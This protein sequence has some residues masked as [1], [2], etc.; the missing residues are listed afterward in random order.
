MKIKSL[1]QK[2]GNRRYSIPGKIYFFWKD[3]YF[4]RRLTRNKFSILGLTTTLSLVFVALFAL[5]LSP[6]DP[7]KI[8]PQNM[9]P[10]SQEFPLGTDNLG[11]CILSRIIYGAQ[12]S[13]GVA[14]SAV[15]FSL[16]LGIILG[17]IAGYYEGFWGG[18]IMRGMDVVLSFPLIILALGIIAALGPSV[19]N[20]IFTIGV[21]YTPTFVRLIYG[22][23]LSTKQND[24][25]L[26]LKA[27]GSANSRI[28]VLHVLP[29]IIAPI[30]VQTSLSL[31]TAILTESALSFLGLGAQ[32]PTPSWGS[33]ISESRVMMELAPWSAI[34]PGMAISLAVLGF[35]FLGDGLRDAFDQLLKD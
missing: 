8:F 19:V 4:I 11:R 20:L 26:A 17:L 13:I 15:F 3:L 7:F 28:L 23:V 30:I 18:I 2:S 16:S 22:S 6:H 25:V 24:Y 27:L 32:P 14:F 1:I 31:S 34:Y 29:N 12:V 9:S 35:N 10:P 5:Y 21:V 33:M